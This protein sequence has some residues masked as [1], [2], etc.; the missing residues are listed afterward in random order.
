MT[1]DP[2]QV[3]P[4]IRRVAT[5]ARLA[6]AA[7]AYRRAAPAAKD[8]AAERLAKALAEARGLP[9]KVGQVLAGSGDNAFAAAL[10]AVPPRPFDAVMAELEAALGCDRSVPFAWID[11]VGIAA[12]IGQV[13]AARLRSGRRVAIK[14]RH[15]EVAG[16]LATELALLGWVPGRGPVKA[17]GIDLDAWRASVADGLAEELDFAAE[18][19]AQRTLRIGLAGLPVVVPEV[20]ERWS[21][22]AVL[23]QSWEDGEPLS[24]ATAWT[25]DER[26]DLAAT[27]VRA[28]F[29]SL[30][31]VGRVHA[32]PNPGNLAVRRA[33]PVAVLLDFGATARVPADRAATFAGLVRDLRGGTAAPALRARLVGL[34][35]DGDKLGEI[36]DLL[37]TYLRVLLAPLLSPGRFDLDAW[38]LAGV[39]EDVLGPGKWWFRAASPP[40][41]LPLLRAFAGLVRQVRTLRVDLHWASLFDAEAPAAEARAADA[42]ADAVAALAPLPSGAAT[43]LTIEVHEG[44]VRKVRAS[45]PARQ[46]RHLVTLM[47]PS[48]VDA[49]REAAVDLGAA[50]DRAVG[51]GFVPQTLIDWAHGDRRWRLW[52]E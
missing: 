47:P 33:G 32:D 2:R 3:R 6:V 34:G 21:T 10:D 27:L 11:P 31:T 44:G 17:F 22:D 52:L 29:R 37:P 38:P 39:G 12:S 49:A 26:A 7:T 18:A 40:D 8:A 35:F 5:L 45:V 13:H 23:V 28:F 48:A 42:D 24:A 9:H 16:A 4:S 51:S 25:D 15:P 43:W 36:E 46:A 14:V 41:A 30:F 50:S 20:V 19:E 1:A